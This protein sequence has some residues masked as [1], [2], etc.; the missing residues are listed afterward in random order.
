MI[1][2]AKWRGPSVFYFSVTRPGGEVD[3]YSS[4]VTCVDRGGARTAV[5]P[6][7]SRLA[8][9]PPD[10]EVDHSRLLYAVEREDPVLIER[11]LKC[12]DDLNRRD[13][14]GRT[15]LMALCE[16][17]SEA[18]VGELLRHKADPCL[19]DS[20]GVD[21]LTLAARRKDGCATIASLLLQS[22]ATMLLQRRVE[23]CGLSGR[24][25]LNGRKGV[26]ISY[27]ERTGRYGVQLDGKG[28]KLALRPEN[29]AIWSHPGSKESTPPQLRKPQQQPAATGES[30]SPPQVS[31]PSDEAPAPPS[32]LTSP[33]L[34]HQPKRTPPVSPQRDATDPSGSSDGEQGGFLKRGH[35]PSLTQFGL[36]D[37]VLS[38][39][40]LSVAAAASKS[41]AAN[42]AAA[43][44]TPQRKRAMARADSSTLHP[45]DSPGSAAKAALQEVH[46]R[47][48]AA[49]SLGESAPR[50]M[51][52]DGSGS[53]SRIRRPSREMVEAAASILGQPVEEMEAAAKSLQMEAAAAKQMEAAAA[54]SG[55]L[56]GGEEHQQQ[57]IITGGAEL[58]ENVEICS[59][60]ILEQQPRSP[61]Q[62]TMRLP[63]T[64]DAQST[65]RLP[66]NLDPKQCSGVSGA[67][68]APTTPQKTSS[69]NSSKRG[70]SESAS[71]S[72]PSST[73]PALQETSPAAALRS[74]SRSPAA[75]RTRSPSPATRPD[76][77]LVD[78]Y[79]AVLDRLP[80]TAA[81][82]APPASPPTLAIWTPSARG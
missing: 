10:T 52:Q 26:A 56:G 17:G 41:D 8:T 74:R 53:A 81:A 35:L 49:M 44:S 34:E 14:N 43:V 23:L 27:E 42:E 61:A 32:P 45:P 55:L 66:E 59:S 80:G 29:L 3:K 37:A 75:L 71:A 4:R 33:I 62:S 36:G 69:S 16:R 73:T 22:H 7:L 76:G 6:L 19:V 21:A 57:S 15:L 12:Y 24:P 68:T 39:N 79:S 82:S 77:G 18:M 64:A 31:P 2:F 28:E 78:P 48:K 25:E 67:G 60:P 40:S 11:E 51:A 20:D 30:S 50:P 65:M 38:D 1:C 46:S 72:A 70:S 13:G 58:E 9:M 54:K 5:R 47:A 63:E